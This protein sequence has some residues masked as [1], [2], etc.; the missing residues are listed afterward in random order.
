MAKPYTEGKGWAV[1]LRVKGRDIYRSGYASE[2]AARKAAEAERVRREKAGSSA[3][4]G[5]NRTCAAVA[6]QDYARERLAFLKGARQDAQRINAYLRACA[7][8][9]ICLEKSSGLDGGGV[10]YW[11]VSFAD[12]SVRSVP[13]SLKVEREQNWRENRRLTRLLREA[14]LKSSQA[15]V[16]DIRYGGGRKLDKSLMAHLSSCQ[17]IRHHQNL[18]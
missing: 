8:P 6:F 7:L 18:C 5:P 16:E 17:W 14:K 10:K 13:Q 9:V 15:C 2:A 4:L 3:K 11:N 1:R 12:E